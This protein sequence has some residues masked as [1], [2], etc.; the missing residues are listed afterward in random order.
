MKTVFG[1]L[2]ML[3]VAGCN[4]PRLPLADGAW[5][6]LSEWSGRVVVINYWAEWCAPCRAEIPEF[7]ALYA[8]AG[9]AGPLIIGVNYDELNAVDL[10]GVIRRMDVRFPTLATDPFELL[11]FARPETL[12]TTVLLTP[13]GHVAEV[14]RGPQ[15]MATL[16]A[17][18]ER[19]QAIDD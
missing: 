10:Q 5:T 13:A 4:D 11:G 9:A 1:L 16:R 3:S 15:T 12:P 8:E 18:I 7:N 2:V 14:L 19:T 6:R 17:A